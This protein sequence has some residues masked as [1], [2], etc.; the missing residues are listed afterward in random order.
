MNQIKYLFGR[1]KEIYLS[2]INPHAGEQG[3]LGHEKKV[4]SALPAE[5]KGPLPGD[6][7]SFYLRHPNDEWQI[8]IYA[9][10]DQGLGFF[11]GQYAMMG[12]QITF[13]LDF[14]RFSVD[15]GTAFNLYGENTAN[16]MGLYT[17]FFGGL[18]HS[19][20]YKEHPKDLT[21]DIWNIISTIHEK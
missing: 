11:K 14:V 1:P 5:I 10:H 20:S 7:L 4:F 21:Q 2:G 3:L 6:S 9:F 16:P 12:C 19:K 13:G 18:A 8:F 17:T 15:H